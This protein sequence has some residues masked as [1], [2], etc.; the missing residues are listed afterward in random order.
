M[1]FIVMFSGFIL[2]NPLNMS[3]ERPFTLS[4]YIA[5][6]PMQSRLSKFSE[7]HQNATIELLRSAYAGAMI[8][9]AQSHFSAEFLRSAGLSLLDVDVVSPICK[10]EFTEQRSYTPFAFFWYEPQAMGVGQSNNLKSAKV[11]ILYANSQLSGAETLVM[12]D[13]GDHLYIVPK[14]A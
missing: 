13:C 7:S 3:A 9:N 12:M 10:P 11:V 1:L 2:L 14:P 6:D 4:R 5:A 8:F